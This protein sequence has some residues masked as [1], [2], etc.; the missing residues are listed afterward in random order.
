M[1]S[2]RSGRLCPKLASWVIGIGQA[3]TS[4]GYELVDLA[5]WPLPMDDEPSVPAF[6]S[7]FRDHTHAWSRKVAGADAIVFVT[8]QYN[9]GYP[10]A[11]KNAI[12]HL[13]GEWA[14]KP[15]MIVSYGRRGGDKC[16]AQLRE[17]AE[18]LKMRPVATMPGIILTLEMIEGGP[19][20]PEK[21]FQVHVEDIRQAFGEL[22]ALLYAA[23]F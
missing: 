22:A 8:P 18:G 2:V 16:A 21:D 11:L 5:D 19:V 6:G 1:G 20:D 4:L 9:R 14:G 12:D 3:S 13:F 10:A 7:Y 23:S 17:I 15:A